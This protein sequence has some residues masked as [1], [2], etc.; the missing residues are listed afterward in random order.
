[1]RCSWA[2][3]FSRGSRGMMRWAVTNG[4]SQSQGRRREGR[5][6]MAKRRP[7]QSRRETWKRRLF[8]GLLT[9]RTRC[10]RRRDRDGEF[11]TADFTDFADCGIVP[12]EFKREE[13]EDRK[14]GAVGASSL[15][16][17]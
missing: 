7:S 15:R 13:R 14:G 2:S 16:L 9:E 12:E 4:L 5:I 10:S 17:L 1:M 11:L 8:R 6:W 3:Q